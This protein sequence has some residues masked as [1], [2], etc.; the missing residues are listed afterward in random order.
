M[1]SGMTKRIVLVGL[2]LTASVAAMA[3]MPAATAA[4]TNPWKKIGTVHDNFNQ[5]GVAVGGDGS[6]HMVWVRNP[7]SS[8][9]DVVHTP[10][11]LAGTV[12]ANTNV[13]T[14]WA[15]IWPVM[16]L[17]STA[18]GLQAFWGGTRSLNANETNKDLSTTTAPASGSP[19]TLQTGDVETGAGGSAGD[20]GASLGAGGVPLISWDAGSSGV[21][22]HAGTDPSTTNYNVQTQLGGCCGYTP[23]IAMDA[24]SAGPWVVWASNAT[25]HVG[26]YAQKLDPSAG[27]SPI[28]SAS[29]L[30]QSATSYAGSLNFDQQI[31]RTPV[32][33]GAHAA[34]VAYTAGYPST[35]RILLWKLSSAGVSAPMVIAS[36]SGAELRTPGVAADASGRVWVTWS[37][38]N[39][40]GLPVV[41]AR[42]SNPAVTKF[43]A[44]VSVSKAP[45]GTC[46]SLFELTPAAASSRLHEVATYNVSCSNALG[47]YY[48]QL[49]PGLTLAASPAHFTGKSKVV[50]TVT[51]AGVAV[52]GATVTI[53][54]KSDTTDSKG[55][56]VITLGPVKKKTTFTA[57]AKK[58]NY[59][60]ARTTVVVK[61]T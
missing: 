59:V 15:E 21:F 26:L 55:H 48:T 46:P 33:S 18:N 25:N 9:Q 52:N 44:T 31:T 51:D 49:F 3:V 40:N 34:Y 28:G 61:P 54:G 12:G 2:A 8:T 23:D 32:A 10:V 60:R 19:W 1:L 4:G 47:L 45:V 39:A 14:G 56:A 43:G 58:H 20:I 53:A 7:T 13:Q 36:T 16:D 30:P 24:S 35:N 22:V 42:R 29:R 50:F 11:S 41:Y 38:N 27:Y 37:K 5:P 57:T 6:L 17:I